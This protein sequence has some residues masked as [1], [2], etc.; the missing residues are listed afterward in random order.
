MVTSIMYVTDKGANITRQLQSPVTTDCKVIDLDE[1]IQTNGLSM[2]RMDR[3]RQA[4]RPKTDRDD[5]F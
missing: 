5:Q 2:H 4:N 3:H 1:T